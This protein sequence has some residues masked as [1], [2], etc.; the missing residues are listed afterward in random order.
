MKFIV[1]AGKNNIL[2]EGKHTAPANMVG[3]GG[4]EAKIYKTKK[5][6]EKKASIFHQGRVVQLN[7]RGEDTE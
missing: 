4:Y 5:A 3:P 1:K 6:A 7:E 2:C